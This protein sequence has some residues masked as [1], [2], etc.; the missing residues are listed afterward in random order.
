MNIR[1][2]RAPIARL[3]RAAPR[4]ISLR[5]CVGRHGADGI[6]GDTGHLPAS[7]SDPARVQNQPSRDVTFCETCTQNRPFRSPPPHRYAAPRATYRSAME[8]PRRPSCDSSPTPST[9]TD[10][11]TRIQTGGLAERSG[12]DQLYAYHGATE[13]HGTCSLGGGGATG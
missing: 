3:R 1:S 11:R 8:L 13:Y 9:H 5:L 4:R 12:R 7:R 2:A 6:A 10:K